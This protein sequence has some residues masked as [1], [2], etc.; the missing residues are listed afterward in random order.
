MATT[1]EDLLKQALEQNAKLLEQVQLLTEQVAY[2]TQ[3]RFGRSSEQINPNQ[4]SLLEDDSVFTDPE[5]TGQQ[6][7]EAAKRVNQTRKPKAKRSEILAKDLPVETTVITKND[8]HCEHGHDLKP[9]GKHLLREEVQVVRARLFVEKVYVQS[10]KCDECEQEDGCSHVYQADA[11]KALI[12]HSIATPSLIAS[13]LHQKYILA[14]PLYRQLK[15]WQRAGV[16]LSETT[17]AN[18]VIKCAELVKPVYDDMRSRLMSQR[19]LQGDET[20]YQVLNEPG[21]TATSKSYVWVARSITRTDQ[22]VVLYA[23]ANTRSGHFAQSLYEGFRGVLQCD[24][25]AG[26]NLLSDSVT[27]VGCWAHVRRKFFA[28]FTYTKAMTKGLKL[29]NQMFELEAKWNNLSSA[30]CLKVRQQELKPLIERFWQW[31]DQV[32]TLPK[33][34]LGKAIAYAQGQRVPLNRVLDYGEIDLT[35]NASERNMKTYVIGRKNWLF[36]T[37]PKGAEANAIWMTMIET[38]K[39]NGLDPVVYLEELLKKITELPTF[40]KNEELEACLPW[41]LIQ[42]S[43]EIKNLA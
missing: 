33:G 36:S 2:L 7:E 28:D 19:F 15:D 32:D 27:R 22:P 18:W 3:H 24:G 26:Y 42:T 40:A 37:S 8:E 12:A 5:Q 41:N 23:Y 34:R 30:E 14:T 10:Y 16:L 25:Y 39:A 1:T 20:P 6:S 31:C 17:I 13:I 35:N 21:K 43:D 29:I 38:A 9:F 11:P 4:T